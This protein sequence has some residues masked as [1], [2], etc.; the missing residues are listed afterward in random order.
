VIRVRI[1]TSEIMN[2]IDKACIESLGIPMVVMMENAALKAF[3]YMDVNKYNRYVVVCGPGNNGGDGFAV[4]RHLYVERKNIDVFLVGGVNKLSEA[5]AVNYN[6]LKN[7]GVKIRKINNIEDVSDLRDCIIEAD[8]TIDAIFGT[9]LNKP[10]EGVYDSVI[11]IVNENSINIFSI[12]VPSGLNGDSGFPM[13]NAIRAHKTVTF[14]MYKRGFLNYESG[15]YSGDIIVENIGIPEFI[16][17]SFH[18]REFITERSDVVNNIKER[19]KYNHKGNYGKALIAAGSKGFTGAA[20]IST[21]ASVKSGCGLVTLASSEYVQNLISGRITEAMT[22][23]IDDEKQFSRM[24]KA[25]NAAAVGPG[26][27]NNEKTFNIVKNM[28]EKVEN[29]IVIDAD[30]INVLVGNT[31]LLKNNKANIIITPHLGEMSRITGLSIEY[32]RDNRVDVAKD[33]AKKYG[34]TVLLKGYQTVITDGDT[35]YINPT[36]NSS[37]ASGGMG[38]CLTGI[39]TSLAAQ[40][41]NCLS[42]AFCG[43]YIHGYIGEKLSESMY[44]VNASHIIDRMPFY[45]REILA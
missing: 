34:V 27:G 19:D 38:D 7:M 33:F 14:E 29:P 22:I 35:T 6:I 16:K 31:E 8:V 11:T 36:G 18:N 37:M 43:A 32:I 28:I 20:V 30:G 25:C 24:M 2:N 10:V 26:L 42:A 45:I 5:C 12:D 21:E 23:N 15:K 13:G 44:S 9:G 4:A 41:L 1:G 17:D 3:K 40:G 39:I